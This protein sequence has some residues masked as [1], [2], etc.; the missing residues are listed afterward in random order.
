MKVGIVVP[1]SWS[2]WGGVVE[3][4][5]QQAR[6]LSELGHD[7]RIIIGNDP[8]GLLSTLLHPRAGRH[9]QPPGFVIPVGRTVVAPANAS[10][11]NVCLTPQTIL[12]MKRVFER[13]QFDLVHVHEPY[14]PIISLAALYY[15]TCPLVSTTHATDGRW[16]KWGRR[17][18]GVLAERI[19]YLIAVSE[20]AR[21]AAQSYIDGPIEIVPNGV[22][23]PG[24]TDPGGREH[25][26]VFVGR[27]EQRKGLPVLLRAWATVHERTGAR[28]RVVGADPLAVRF[29]M[30]RLQI[31][32]EGV[33]VLGVLTTEARDA[34][35][36]SAKLLA[37]PAIGHESFGMVL[38]EAFAL[39]T[40]VVASSI[41]GYREVA[42]SDTGILVP[43][44]DV[45]ALADALVELL[46]DEPRRR[47]LGER[48]RE[49]AEEHYSWE[50]VAIRL[51]AIYESLVP[52]RVP[53]GIAA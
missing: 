30:R 26:V 32:D 27:Q 52:V 6:A 4:A 42:G 50:R 23:V 17:F 13:E 36:A 44:G 11:S 46:E 24:A 33:D 7:V 45:E 15:A 28:L 40:P 2:Y 38:T 22:V 41:S 1:F 16:W 18:W 48:A 21:S 19:D 53:T 12:R 31:T 51:A 5:E 39:A 34:E 3:H 20:H 14:V 47:A 29:L 43:P 49:V 10:L 37:A 35:I 8:P 9:G 25:R